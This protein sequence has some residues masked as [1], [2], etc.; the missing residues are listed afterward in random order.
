[1]NEEKIIKTGEVIL[2]ITIITCIVILLLPKQSSSK[3]EKLPE[4]FVKNF[5]ASVPSS[6]ENT[7]LNEIKMLTNY[8]NFEDSSISTPILIGEYKNKIDTP[9]N[10]LITEIAPMKYQ[11]STKY[12]GKQYYLTYSKNGDETQKL[13]K[14]Q[15][16]W[17]EDPTQKIIL[18]KKNNKDILFLDDLQL[19]FKWM[20]NNPEKR[21]NDFG[22]FI[23]RKGV[24]VDNNIVTY[25]FKI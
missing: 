4:K 19:Y 21:Q 3:S 23:L 1:M 24:P 6:S 7:Q 8:N 2:I 22:I 12:N 14:G 16:Y 20:G 9:V 5:Q 18:S 10:L 25:T 13:E 17:V 15:L 11:F